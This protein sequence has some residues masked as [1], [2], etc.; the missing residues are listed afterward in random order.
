MPLFYDSQMFDIDF[1]LKQVVPVSYYM[2]NKPPQQ[3]DQYLYQRQRQQDVLCFPGSIYTLLQ[4]TF[5]VHCIL[6]LA[7]SVVTV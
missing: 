3:L 5:L 4:H 7:W 1:A 6:H 2:Y